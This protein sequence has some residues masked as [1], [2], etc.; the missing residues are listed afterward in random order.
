MTSALTGEYYTFQ[1]FAD[2]RLRLAFADAVNITDIMDT[3]NNKLGQ[4]AINVVA[5]GLPP[6]GSFFPNDKPLYS[7][8]LDNAQNLLLAAM[9]NP[10]TSFTFD[11]RDRG[12]GRVLQQLV[13]LHD[14]H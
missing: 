5:P 11:E 2:Q 14:A 7:F 10:L 3:V 13:R 6:A 12:S 1:P 9:E 8:N 4:T